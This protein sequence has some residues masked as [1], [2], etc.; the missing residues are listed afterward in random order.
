VFVCSA[1]VGEMKPEAGIYGSA[2]E[3]L[4]AKGEEC[5]FIDDRAA[6]LEPARA[7]GMNGIQLTSA[8]QVTAELKGLGV[9]V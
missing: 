6:N 4:Q 7:L 8:E 3:L 2:L 5:V 9:R 1:Y